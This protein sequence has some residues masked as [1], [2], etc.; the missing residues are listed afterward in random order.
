MNIIIG[1]SS[2]PRIEILRMKI[3]NS[4]A[5]HNYC[6]IK[7]YHGMAILYIP[8]AKILPSGF[9]EGTE[10]SIDELLL[11]FGITQIFYGNG[12]NSDFMKKLAKD[13]HVKITYQ[14]F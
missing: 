9:V 8:Y 13:Y 11:Q 5:I 1:P 3:P 7:K 4:V 14:I 2:D 6:K 12:V 10:V